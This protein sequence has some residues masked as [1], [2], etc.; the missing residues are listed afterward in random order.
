MEYE[1]RVPDKYSN[2]ITFEPSRALLEPNEALNVVAHFTPLR[3]KEYQITVPLFTRNLFDLK[4]H[5]IG[6]FNPGS[7]SLM[8]D[9]HTESM[10]SLNTFKA[11]TKNI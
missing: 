9:H 2:E 8:V 3:K 6:Y 4:K 5:A 10:L 11:A 1:W 7:G